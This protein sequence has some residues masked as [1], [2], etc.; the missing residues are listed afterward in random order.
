MFH[1]A[2]LT[3]MPLPG[4][5]FPFTQPGIAS[6]VVRRMHEHRAS[7]ELL[8][9]NYAEAWRISEGS[10]AEFRSRVRLFNETAEYPG[11]INT[12]LRIIGDRKRNVEFAAEAMLLPLDSFL[13]SLRFMLFGNDHCRDDGP[14]LRYSITVDRA[15]DAIGNYARHSFE[16]FAHDFNNTWPS[17]FQHKSIRPLAQ[18]TTPGRIDDPA[19]AYRAFTAVEL[20]G[21]YVLDLLAKYG[22]DGPRASYKTVEGVVYAAAL[23]SINRRF[24]TQSTP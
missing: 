17:S 6:W 5:F 13:G 2:T 24:G 8:F 10:V 1:R 20:P 23:G 14:V 7:Y 16:W 22:I 19:A 12:D 4:A 21:A 3:P 11:D 15:L 18:L 9:G